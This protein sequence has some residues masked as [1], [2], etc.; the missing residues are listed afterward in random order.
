M[1]G[2]TTTAPS[3]TRRPAKTPESGP[4]GGSS[5]AGASVRWLP[6][7]A[8]TALLVAL[9][10]AADTAPLDVLRYL[11]YTLWGVVLPGTLLFRALRRTPHTLVEDLAFGAVTGLVLELLAW[12]ALVSMGLQSVAVAWPLVVVVPFLLVPGL[13]RHWAP[14]GYRRP[15]LGWSWSVAGLVALTSTYMYAVFLR[16]NPIL[17]DTETTR[18][19]IDLPY[20]LSL[21][22]NAKENFPLTFPQVAGEPLNYHWF[23][24][25]HMAMGDLVGQVDLPVIQMR[26]MVP[27]LSALFMVITAVVGQ[28]LTGRAWVGPV[29]A[30][31]VFGIGEFTVNYP[32][33]VSSWAFG[34]PS[35]PLMSWASLSLTY[36]QPLLVG[37]IGVVGDRLRGHAEAERVPGL[38]AGGLVLVALLAFGSSAAKASSLPVTLAG[39]AFAGVAVLIL[40]RRINWDIVA[41]GAILGGVQLF[42]TAVI[43]RF[44]SYGLEVVPF[45]NIMG[46]WADPEH[47]RSTGFQAAVVGLVLVAFLLNHQLRLVGMVPLIWRR[48]LR[49]EPVQWFLLGGALAGPALY[50]VVNGFNSSYFTLAGLPFG[51]LLSAWGYC[52]TFERAELSRRAKIWL[53]VGTLTFVGLLTAAILEYSGRWREQV[54]ELFGD[55]TAGRSYSTLLPALTAAGV[56]TGAALGAG[57]LWWLLGRVMP[58]LRRRGGVVLLSAALVA[59]APTLLLDVAQS[60]DQEWEGSWLMPASQVEAAR[61]IRT[62]SSPTDV[63]ATGVHCRSDDDYNDPSRGCGNSLAFWLSAYSERSV[64]IEGWA[65]SPRL[66]AE[67]SGAFWD[68]QLLKLNDDAFKQP[69][70]DGLDRLHDQHA[71][72]YLVVDRKAGGASPELDTL[73]RKAYDNGRVAV[74]E[75]S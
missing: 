20:L 43:F 34:A 50:L 36:C 73:A 52:E 8:A 11:G 33:N 10:L 9:L 74:Y 23:T 32:A 3:R 28:R 65:Y 22:G 64:L 13:R 55:A 75:L 69:T 18:Q 63:L 58:A 12:A 70:R 44:E 7:L 26:L 54:L 42:A 38:G 25:A 46:Y 37:L 27:A 4:V 47:T 29:A 17:P 61:W 5:R 67:H 53:A 39:L 45:G 71:V 31:L 19:Y 51:I 68:Q 48:R 59:G 62:N 21:A 24:F 35:V 49:L 16:K 60:R 15:S 56:L 40:A 30:L 57:L 66:M 41:L 14:R 1:S 2:S 6:A 72:R